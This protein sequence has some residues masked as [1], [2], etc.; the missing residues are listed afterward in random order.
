MEEGKRSLMNFASHH[1]QKKDTNE[2]K[3]VTRFG[4]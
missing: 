4:L 3:I 1:Y 2:S